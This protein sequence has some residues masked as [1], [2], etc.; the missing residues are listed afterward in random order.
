MNRINNLAG[1]KI[2]V[3]HTFHDEVN[4]CRQH[5]W[6]CTGVCRTMKPFMGFVKRSMNRAPGPHDRWFADHR[7]K[8][9]G[10]FLMISFF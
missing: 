7:R 9:S 8:C 2:T 5:V 10:I 4:H 6:R 1:T 3:Y